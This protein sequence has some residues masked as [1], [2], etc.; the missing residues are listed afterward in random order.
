MPYRQLRLRLRREAQARSSVHGATT[1]SAF[2]GVV[3]VEPVVPVSRSLCGGGA[4]HALCGVR[5]L[6]G[7]R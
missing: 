3:I 7:V 2:G 1:V 6:G 5:A 4:A